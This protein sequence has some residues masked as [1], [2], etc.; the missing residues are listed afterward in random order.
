[1]THG[2]TYI[3]NE[4]IVAIHTIKQLAQIVKRI[5]RA[6]GSSMLHHDMVCYGE[7]SL[8]VIRGQGLLRSLHRGWRSSFSLEA[9]LMWISIYRVR[10]HGVSVGTPGL[11]NS[12]TTSRTPNMDLIWNKI[13]EAFG[14][15]LER[16]CGE[17]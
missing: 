8:G 14:V 16:G 10:D 13:G 11:G 7:I 17:H 9:L 12:N 1:V 6:K 3:Y 4:A 5:K 2:Y 15:E